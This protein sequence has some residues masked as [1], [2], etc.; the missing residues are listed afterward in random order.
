MTFPVN[1]DECGWAGS[2][3]TAGRA[4]YAFRRHSCDKHRRLAARDERRRLRE[5][6]ADRTPKPCRH[7]QAR[8]EHGTKAAYSLDLCRCGPCSAAAAEYARVRN[9]QIAYG[10]WAAYVD[11]EPARLHVRALGAAGLG[12]KKAATAAGI[13]TGTMSKLL[14]GQSKQGVPPSLRIRSRTAERILAVQIG[15]IAAGTC[16][17]ATGT[18]RRLQALVAIG[19]SQSKLAIRLGMGRAN[20]SKVICGS[21][22]R[23][24]TADAVT[25][26]YLELWDQLPP[27]ESHRDRIAFS[28]S[29]GYAAE[30]GWAPPMAWDDDK[31]DDPEA[32]PVGVQRIRRPGQQRS[33]A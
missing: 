6:T 9:R 15:T 29:R 28:R 33:V 17:D 21:L 5:A 3:L 32:R 22:V 30:L 25:R 20:F 23:K 10:R 27:R 2:Y 13:S 4:D 12:W 8:H 16:I 14:Y 31:I 26:L 11:A 19:W 7:K 1:C 24:S 18:R